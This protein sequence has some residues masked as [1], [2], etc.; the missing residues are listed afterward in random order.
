MD[1][2]R[3]DKLSKIA[4][5]GCGIAGT[6]AGHLLSAAGHE[7]TLFEQA[8]KCRPVGAGIM[9][10]P[11]GQMVLRRLGIHDAIAKLSTPL[12]GMEA[13][14]ASGKQLVRLEYASL[15][16]QLRAWGVHRGELFEQLLRLCLSSGAKVE[17]SSLITHYASDDQQVTVVTQSGQEFG[18]FDFLITTDGSRSRLRD[19]A[20]IRFQ[21]V[22]YPY[23]A[24]WAT[25]PC[26][27][28][29]DRLFQVVDGTKRLVGLLP[30]GSGRCSFFWGLRADSYQ[31]LS[32]AGIEPWKA[33]VIQLCPQAEA[34]LQSI[35]SFDQLTFATYRHVQMR[36]WHSDR[37]VFLGDACHASSPHLGQGESGVGRCG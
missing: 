25:G 13:R 10:Q 33:E 29:D 2:V 36:R 28:V 1:A 3:L 27:T 23:A 9:L 5:S 21:S 17:T 19:A 32:A 24:I 37:I 7:V 8:S 30:I 15:G 11:S 4:I 22:E 35:A 26:D 18:G 34:F 12:L 14:L 6:A 16:D 20:G 31:R